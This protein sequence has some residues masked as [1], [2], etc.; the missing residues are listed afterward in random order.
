VRTLLGVL[1]A[2]LVLAPLAAAAVRGTHRVAGA[3]QIA[4]AGRT[5]LL[6]LVEGVVVL[7]VVILGVLI[8]VALLNYT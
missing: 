4:E 3:D 2:V 5:T 8:A 7:G 6:T 1:V